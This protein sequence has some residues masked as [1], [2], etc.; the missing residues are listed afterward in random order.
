VSIEWNG[1]FYPAQVLALE[2]GG[3][4]VHYVGWDAIWDEVVPFARV[5]LSAG[6]AGGSSASVVVPTPAYPTGPVIVPSTPGAPSA[7]A[8]PSTP[9]YVGPQQPA[10]MPPQQ[11][12]YVPPQQPTYVPPQQPTYVPPQ[13]PTSYPQPVPAGRPNLVVNGSFEQPGL[14][15]GSWNVFPAMPGWQ[16]TAGGGIEVQN[17]VAGRSAD[18]AHHV[19]LDGH[20]STSIAQDIQTQAGMTYELRV[21]FAARPGTSAE[22]NVLLVLWNGQP[23]A[24]LVADGSAD[25]DAR[26][27]TYTG[28][29]TANGPRTR[30]ELRDA[31]P[32]NSMGTYL[33]DVRLTATR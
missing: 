25:A 16:S 17:G 28:W 33:D 12:A 11:P 26:W 31:G 14:A 23:V 21:S 9:V 18:G 22:D 32:S 10:Y 4:R 15:P 1:S 29:V 8:I 3:V 27:T 5:Q 30:L 20:A 19:E 24:R 6:S 7:P 2:G 13:Q